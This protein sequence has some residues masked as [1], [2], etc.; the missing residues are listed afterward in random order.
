[1][2]RIQAEVSRRKRT[3][4]AE[5]SAS[6]AGVAMAGPL[7]L[8]FLTILLLIVGPIVIRLQSSGV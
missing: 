1:V 7:M 8:V 4:R 6:K 5:E 2:L 3:V